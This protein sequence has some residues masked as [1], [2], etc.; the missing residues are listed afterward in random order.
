MP[1]GI[2]DAADELPTG[3]A[4]ELRARWRRPLEWGGVIAGR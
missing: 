2:I 1:A 3:V 4:S